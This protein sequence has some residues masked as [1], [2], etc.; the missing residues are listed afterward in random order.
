MTGCCTKSNDQVHSQ[1]KTMLGKIGDRYQSYCTTYKTHA[2]NTHHGGTEHTDKGR[3]L[4]P[5]IEDTR[6]MDIGPC[7]NN[8]SRNSSDTMIASR[9]SQVDGHLS[10]LLLNSQ[11]NLGIL[12]REISSLRQCIEARGQSVERLDHIDH[13]DQELWNL[14]CAQGTADFNPSPYRAIWRSG[15][16]INRHTMHHA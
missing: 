2:M 3:D 7:N 8:K 10:D 9:G 16:P 13:L 4:D 11:A 5:H 1:L 6:G 15:M 14:S 12:A